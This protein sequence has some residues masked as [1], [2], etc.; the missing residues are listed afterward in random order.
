[1][2]RMGPGERMQEN[3]EKSVLLGSCLFEQDSEGYLNRLSSVTVSLLREV[4]LL[5]FTSTF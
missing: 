3:L 4:V 2:L 1:M 5:L